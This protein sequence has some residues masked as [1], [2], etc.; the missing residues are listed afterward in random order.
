[1]RDESLVMPITL[2]IASSSLEKDQVFKLRHKVFVDE[3]NRFIDPGERV[4]DHFDCFDETKNI[5]AFENDIPVGTIRVTLANQIGLPSEEHYDFSE[6]RNRIDGK[7]ACIGWLCCLKKYRRHPGLL[8][9]LIK[10]AFREMRKENNR[11]ILATIHP[12]IYKMLQRIFGANPVDKEFKSGAL[13]VPMIPIHVDLENLPANSREPLLLDPENLFLKE[14]NER[15]IYFKNEP[16]FFRG[17]DSIEAFCIMRGSVRIVP[18]EFPPD[19]IQRLKNRNSPLN[20]KD[21]LLSKGELFGELSLIDGEPRTRSAICYS[22]EL[23]VMVWSK[24]DIL[25]QIRTEP[26]SAFT[27]TRIVSSR[28][29]NQIARATAV[30][31]PDVSKIAL[32]LYFATNEGKQPSSVG[33]LGRQCGVWG[34]QLK[35]ILNQW[36]DKGYVDFV[37]DRKV[38]VVNKKQLRKIAG[39]S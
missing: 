8:I 10:V 22:N 34:N 19:E 5:I 4:I 16:V 24:E 9:G 39:L 38:S 15:R 28:F 37:S 13:Q 36:L 18:A 2:K 23:D 6:Y 33:W 17:E 30:P 11:H 32:I 31:K 35:E 12:P 7:C 1:M 14:S 3:E 26:Q 25:E 29:R 21:V 20:E 27:L